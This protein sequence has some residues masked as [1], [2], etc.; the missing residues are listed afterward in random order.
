M[1]FVNN[2]INKLKIQLKNHKHQSHD[3]YISIWEHAHLSSQQS[4]VI[5][6]GAL[7]PNLVTA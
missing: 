3:N 1:I 2:L 4:Q 7:K 5:H 6:P